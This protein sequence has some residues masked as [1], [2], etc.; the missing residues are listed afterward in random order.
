[1]TRWIWMWS[2]LSS[3]SKDYPSSTQWK[4]AKEKEHSST[5][6]LWW[7]IVTIMATRLIKC[8][9][10]LFWV[11]ASCTTKLS[12]PRATWSQLKCKVLRLFGF[13][14]PS[15]L[16][17]RIGTSLQMACWRPF[18]LLSLLPSSRCRVCQG[19]IWCSEVHP[20][21]MATWGRH[22]MRGWIRWDLLA[23]LRLL[24]WA[25]TKHQSRIHNRMIHRCQWRKPKVLLC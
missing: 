1:M 7:C 20:T 15:Y 19:K 3:K 2:N 12:F 16:R 14:W 24:C 11:H 23:C 9:P 21:C 18:F 4:M 8:K 22:T 10:M 6:H 17:N 13:G 5:S 25:W